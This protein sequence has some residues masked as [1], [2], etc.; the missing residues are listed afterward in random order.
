M[1]E[2]TINMHVEILGKL[3]QAALVTGQS[4]QKI[5]SFMLKKFADETRL[6]LSPWSRI[7]YQGRDSRNNWHRLHVALSPAE[8]ELLLDL[9]KACKLSGSRIIAYAIEKYLFDLLNN[10]TETTDNYRLN[11]YI[12]LYGSIDNVAYCVQYWGMPTHPPAFPSRHSNI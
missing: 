9:K 1:I 7:R 2:S 8:Y 5:I 6:P 11:S 10:F 4:R 12:L 3:T